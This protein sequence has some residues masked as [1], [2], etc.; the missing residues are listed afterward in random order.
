MIKNP[1]DNISLTDQ[2]TSNFNAQTV[3]QIKRALLLT[4][5]VSS[6]SSNKTR[7]ID[8]ALLLKKLEVDA[9]TIQAA[10]LCDPY[11]RNTD[12]RDVIVTEFGQ[13]VS[14]L[15][16][17]VSRLNTFDYSHDILTKPDQAESLRRMLL[18]MIEDVRAVLIKLAF[19]V[20]RLRILSKEDYEVRKFIAKETLDIYAPL[21][22]RLGIAQLKW[23]LEDL[24]FR[25]LQPQTYKHIA[26]A[27]T[28]SRQEREQ[29]IENF[30]TDINVLLASESITASVYGR[31]KHIYSI[32]H[33]M[34]KKQLIVD[35]LYDQR[36]IRIIVDKIVTCYTVLGLVHGQW[37]Y[38]PK[39]FDDYIANPK[40]N[41]YQSLHTVVIGSG[42]AMVEIQIRTQEMHDFAELGVAAHWRYKEQ[43]KQDDALEKN[44]TSLRR[45]LDH[46][47]TA[48]L[49]E[50]FR[51]ELYADRIFALTPKGEIKDLPKGATP[52]DFAYAIHTEVGHR[53]R[54][55]KVNGHIVPLTHQLSSGERVEI[56]TTNEG[57]PNRGW[58]NSNLNYIV[59]PS[60]VSKIKLW[61]N[62]QDSQ[63]NFEDGKAILE[64]ESKRFGVKKFDLENLIQRF[65]TKNE[66]DLLIQIGRADISTT[67]LASA[68]QI[69]PNV[70]EEA[71]NIQPA[72][73][74]NYDKNDI[75]VTGL[76]N[77]LTQFA[78][79]CH[80]LPGDAII[81][82]ISHGKGVVIH[83]QGCQNILQL[84]IEKQNRLIDVSW[85]QH[86][87]AYPVKI[88]VK[89]YDRQGLLKD[90]TL[91]LA[92]LH[93]NIT[94]ANTHTNNKD[95]SVSI[96]LTIEANDTH[97]LGQILDKVGQ[98]R[99]VLEVARID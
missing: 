97:Q 34:Q 84:P 98:L 85:G 54:G 35:Q 4:A 96:T 29:F 57:G 12:N 21:A 14:T 45:L 56:L 13:G 69:V 6:E 19:R 59:T 20:E 72:T 64:K 77:L 28:E 17:N 42:G 93:V 44:I 75:Y 16:D 91:K 50:N 33:K 39:E 92:E 22:N 3:E 76:G 70:N 48:D 66:K 31:P 55:A 89:A 83:Q 90:I 51:S 58:L 38:I 49:L 63:K 23:Q 43:T 82:Y 46:Q 53:C 95:L 79:C 30:I 24:A 41:G 40:E 86:Q 74:S 71:W 37:Q 94:D 10:L 61:F 32:W 1:I 78:Q 25:Y 60:A 73:K 47:N 36:A 18:A 9:E 81:G 68:L 27:L 11:F 80:P 88:L 5:S 67:R 2:L 65:K 62:Q 26:S 15:V 7:G 52:I 87:A 99:N 8:V